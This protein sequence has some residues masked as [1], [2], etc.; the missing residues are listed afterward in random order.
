MSK[1]SNIEMLE[2]LQKRYGEILKQGRIDWGGDNPHPNAVSTA[3]DLMFDI[4]ILGEL[5]KEAKV[6]EDPP[7]AVYHFLITYYLIRLDDVPY[8]TNFMEATITILDKYMAKQ[9]EEGEREA[10]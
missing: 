4:E 8:T 3:K 10:Q 7:G 1:Q 6:R 5:I 2:Y 9:I